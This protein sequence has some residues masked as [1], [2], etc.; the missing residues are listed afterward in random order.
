METTLNTSAN[1]DCPMYSAPETHNSL[2]ANL[3]YD[4]AH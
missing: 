3:V 4:T 1:D 2:G